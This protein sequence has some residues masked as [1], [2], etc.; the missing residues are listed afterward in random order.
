MLIF[1]AFFYISI[2]Y[3]VLS[4]KYW[5]GVF[6]EIIGN[7]HKIAPSFGGSMGEDFGQ[8]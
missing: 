2:E 6:V 7:G 3:K 5:D 8:Y 1:E 4:T